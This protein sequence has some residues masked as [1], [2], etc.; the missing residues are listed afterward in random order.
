LSTQEAYDEELGR[1]LAK[2]AENVRRVREEKFPNLSQEEVAEEADLHRTQWG[3]IEAGKRDPRFSTLLVLTDTLGVSLDDLAA[4]W[5][6][7]EH[8]SIAPRSASVRLVRRLLGVLSEAGSLKEDR[9]HGIQVWALTAKGRK[10]LDQATE[11]LDLPESPQ[12]ARWREA[13]A[14]ATE[15]VEGLHDSLLKHSRGRTDARGAAPEYAGA[16]LSVSAPRA[17]LW[18]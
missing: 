9:R 16:A 7:Y 14:L 8:L 5:A 2:L 4:D 18:Q 6:I 15:E 10:Q 12:H 1:L 13:Y 11:S 3:K 17:R